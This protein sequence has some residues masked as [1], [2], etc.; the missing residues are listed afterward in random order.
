MSVCPGLYGGMPVCMHALAHV[1]ACLSVCLPAQA[2]VVGCLSVSLPVCLPRPMWWDVC[3]SVC[4]VLCGGMFVCLSVCPGLC[5]GMSV[6]LS[7]YPGLCGGMSTILS[8]PMWW[9]VCLSVCLPACLFGQY[10]PKVSGGSSPPY[11]TSPTPA[12]TQSE[13]GWRRERRSHPSLPP[14]T[15]S[16]FP[17]TEYRVNSVQI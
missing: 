10:I 5:G 14:P 4:L 16:R 15:P 9:D 17:A 8:R 3:L 13:N 11:P 1:V 6:Y 12:S 2:Y 7:A